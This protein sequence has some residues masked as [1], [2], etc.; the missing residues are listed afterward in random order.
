MNSI[1]KIKVPLLVVH[2]GAWDIPDDEVQAHLVGIRNAL[3]KGWTCMTRGGTSLEAV[4]ESVALLEDDP[5]FDA[6]K[7]S[8]LNT[9]GS[10][11]MD[12]SI[13][14]GKAFNA[15]AVAALRNFPNPIRIA[16]CVLEKTDHILMAGVGAEEFAR[17]QGF[18]SVPIEE[19][20]TARELK[21]LALLVQDKK[22]HASYSFGKKRGTVGAVA[23]DAQG[24]VAAGTSTGGTPKKLPGRVGDTPLI[25]CGT[26]AENGAGGVSCTGWGEAIM[27]VML[28]RNV[29]ERMRSGI[30]AQTAAKQGIHRLNECAEGLGGVICVDPH[31]GIGVAFNTPRMA[32]GF[33]GFGI[34]SPRV[35]IE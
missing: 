24:N 29:A 23:M 31:G 10:I 26:Y 7:G 15:G 20:L 3:E 18:R 13:M 14:D 9:D 6:V 35:W 17:S 34:E 12:A 22:F 28:A 32:R 5:T 2:G 25:G 30:E 27:K 21:R 33:M 4:E 11:E 16:R 1:K 8:I 19:L